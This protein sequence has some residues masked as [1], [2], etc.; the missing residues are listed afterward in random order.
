MLLHGSY[1]LV[2]PSEHDGYSHFV[3]MLSTFE[4][5][6]GLMDQLNTTGLQR[7]GQSFSLRICE[8]FAYHSHELLQNWSEL[9]WLSVCACSS[10]LLIFTLGERL[11]TS[12]FYCFTSNKIFD[13]LLWLPVHWVTKVCN[14]T[15]LVEE[16]AIRNLFNPEI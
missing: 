15:F 6:I 12:S 13:V 1:V 7:L 9:S 2:F 11:A 5:D 3:L 10:P 8:D 4:A 14:F 16:G